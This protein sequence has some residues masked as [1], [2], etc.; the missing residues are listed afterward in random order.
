[1]TR[2]EARHRSLG[3]RLLG[4]TLQHQT[5]RELARRCGVKE[6]TISALA[7]GVNRYPSLPLAHALE[8]HAGI[9]T[10]AWEQ[11]PDSILIEPTHGQ[12][13]VSAPPRAA[14]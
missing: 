13:E 14:E 2:D 5:A 4:V 10:Q 6:A 12:R 1:V 3:R 8:R 7:T 11:E 9:A